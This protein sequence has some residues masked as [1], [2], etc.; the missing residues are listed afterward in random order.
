MSK[1]I[2]LDAGHG[3]NTAGKRCLKSIDPGQTREWMLND[4]IADRLQ[5]LLGG[6]DCTVLR[7]DDT[8]G[9]RDISLAARVSAANK[10]G[11]AMYISIH[12]NAGINGGTGGGTVVYYYSSAASRAVQARALYEAVV[13]KTGL[14]GNRSEKVKKNGYYVLSKTK[15]PA[16]LLENG[17]M[18]SRTDTPVII[19]PDHAERTAQGVLNFLA[20]ELSLKPKKSQN[21]P[22]EQPAQ[23][24]PACA[25]KYVSIST[26]LAS[27][28]VNSS[29]AYR[30]QIAAANGITGY[31]GT[32][33][34]NT[35]MLNLLKAGILKKV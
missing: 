5:E 19:A 16:F 14:R 21:K 22:Q 17:F 4:R 32:A 23:Y 26:A 28:G 18:D 35:R 31:C 10:A 7:V 34:Q 33:S 15:M 11:A 25:A 13:D 1:T 8:T 29:Y 30:K 12:H 3:Y 6:Y 27:I 24:Y 20:G 9:A 2:A